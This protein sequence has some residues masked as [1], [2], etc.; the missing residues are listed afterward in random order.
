MHDAHSCVKHITYAV[1]DEGTYG[2]ITRGL[3]DA[4]A[5]A[6]GC[7]PARELPHAAGSMLRIRQ[8]SMLQE[9]DL[10]LWKH[11]D[12]LEVHLTPVPILAMASMLQRQH[13]QMRGLPPSMVQRYHNVALPLVAAGITELKG[14]SVQTAHMCCQQ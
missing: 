14:L 4:Q 3:M 9:S 12:K 11:T 13:L 5:T 6:T 10:R 8:L 7:L 1:N 2:A